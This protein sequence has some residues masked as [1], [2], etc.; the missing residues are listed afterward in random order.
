M[1]IEHERAVARAARREEMEHLLQRYPQLDPDDASTLR[2]WF[3]S[4]ASALDVGL[5]S[6]NEAL[7]DA[8]AAFRK[9]HLHR[10]TPAE[11]AILTMLL[12]IAAAA[13]GA[14]VTG[15]MQMA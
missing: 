2:Q 9:D 13:V 15:I 6:A 8:Y 5:L 12:C 3:R 11:L 10:F 7:H 14:L 1:N 4:E